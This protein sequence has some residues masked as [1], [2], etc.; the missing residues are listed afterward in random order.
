MSK[1]KT[2]NDARDDGSHAAFIEA[3][4][5]IQEEATDAFLNHKDELAFKLRELVR[6]F[7][8]CAAQ[9]EVDEA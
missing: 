3:A 6:Y 4:D 9:C 2:A 5:K 7:L 8:E 1:K